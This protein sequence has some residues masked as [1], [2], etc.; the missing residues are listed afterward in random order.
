MNI[1]VRV[2][3]LINRCNSK[4]PFKI[5][6]TLKIRIT[7][8]DIGEIRGY[9]TTCLRKKNIVLNEKLDVLSMKIV[10]AHEL[11]HAI[12]H[13][14]EINLM[15]ETFMFPKNSKVEKEANQFASELLID[16]FLTDEY[17]NF[18]SS[19]LEIFEELCKLKR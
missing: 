19:E 3:N 4:D 1:K 16:E 18:S 11:G 12:L 2:K 14:K 10:L 17:I 13:K 8:K 15:K 9:Y 6:K 7:C 5:C